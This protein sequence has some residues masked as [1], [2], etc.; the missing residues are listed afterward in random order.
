MTI[1]C[2]ILVLMF[3]TGKKLN[4]NFFFFKMDGKNPF[5]KEEP[6]IKNK[7]SD[8]VDAEYTSVDE[9]NKKKK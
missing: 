4:K 1:V 9:G 6:S 5:K 3:F 8:Y 7:K 2:I